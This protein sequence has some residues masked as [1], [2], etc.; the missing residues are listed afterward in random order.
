MPDYHCIPLD[1]RRARPGLDVDPHLAY[2]KAAAEEEHPADLHN[3]RDALLLHRVPSA[4]LYLEEMMAQWP[5]ST[6][7]Q[8]DYLV[9]FPRAG[10][11]RSSVAT[12][13]DFGEWISE[14]RPQS[15][16][17][18]APRFVR[19]PASETPKVECRLSSSPATPP[20]ECTSTDRGLKPEVLRNLSS[21]FRQVSFSDDCTSSPSTRS[22]TPVPS[23]TRSNY[24]RSSLRDTSPCA[25]RRSPTEL[26]LSSPPS[27]T[28][29]SKKPTEVATNCPCILQVGSPFPSP[30]L[31]QDDYLGWSSLPADPSRDSSYLPFR[32][33]P[34]VHA[35]SI[36]LPQPSP[37]AQEVSYIDWDDDQFGDSALD[38]IK[39]SFADLRAAERYITEANYRNRVEAARAVKETS[40][41]T[42]K[43]GSSE[44][45]DI[46]SEQE[47]ASSAQKDKHK[48]P[49]KLRKKASIKKVSGPARSL[50]ADP[51]MPR[52]TGRK[53]STNTTSSQ[54]SSDIDEDKTKN[55]P[56]TKLVQRFLRVR[57]EQ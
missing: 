29:T 22:V 56:V 12:F 33:V 42:T 2:K 24:S 23:L 32:P 6:S 36:H 38:R 19:L 8:S 28:P 27:K 15:L 55:G 30:T 54:P 4:S 3:A 45:G 49:T 37:D 20:K 51:T 13:I 17:P 11:E 34:D 48:K 40:E 57:K 26:P 18:P 9:S 14:Q 35:T 39:K 7:P 31:P 52:S 46:S 25:I 1:F 44:T 21:Q 16:L 5:I 53:G 43:Y 10:D 50:S 41:P 47:P